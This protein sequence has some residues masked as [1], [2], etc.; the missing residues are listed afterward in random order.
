[1][2]Y[3]HCSSVM[4]EKRNSDPQWTPTSDSSKRVKS[5]GKHGGRKQTVTNLTR[6]RAV[7]HPTAR[8]RTCTI[9]LSV[10]S[11]DKEQH[12]R[13]LNLNGIL[14]SKVLKFINHWDYDIQDPRLPHGICATCRIDIEEQL[15]KDIPNFFVF[16]TNFEL[17]KRLRPTL[18]SGLPV[19]ISFRVFICPGIIECGVCANAASYSVNVQ[20]KDTKPHVPAQYVRGVFI[21]N[22]VFSV[23]ILLT[24]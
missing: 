18:P 4:S 10:A 8:R 7:D 22:I 19:N 20:I 17:F 15:K 9:C 16:D 13:D 6:P 2:R 1:M 12:T 5:S 3:L 23:H 14:L 21:F 24:I 11:R